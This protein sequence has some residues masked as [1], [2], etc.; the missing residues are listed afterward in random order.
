MI[1]HLLSLHPVDELRR[2]RE[3]RQGDAPVARQQV[4]G[5]RLSQPIKDQVSKFHQQIVCLTY[6][7]ARFIIKICLVQA[8]LGL[9][10]FVIC[11]FDYPRLFN[12]VQK[13]LSADFS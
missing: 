1:S 6:N 7:T 8:D 4:R 9:R 13:S 11:G 3:R 5:Q 2:R 10:G 12:S